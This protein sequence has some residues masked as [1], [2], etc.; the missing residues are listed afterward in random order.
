MVSG[1]KLLDKD[2]ETAVKYEA[3]ATRQ[4]CSQEIRDM[5]L[6]FYDYSRTNQVPK[7]KVIE[8]INKEFAFLNRGHVSSR[9]RSWKMGI[10]ELAERGVCLL[11]PKISEHRVAELI[12]DLYEQGDKEVST[13][14]VYHSLLPFLNKMGESLHEKSPIIRRALAITGHKLTFK[15]HRRFIEDTIT[16]YYVPHKLAKEKLERLQFIV[17]LK[18]RIAPDNKVW[19]LIDL[20]IAPR[21]DYTTD[22]YEICLDKKYHETPIISPLQEPFMKYILPYKHIRKKQKVPWRQ[23]MALCKRGEGTTKETL[24]TINK[25]IEMNG[26]IPYDHG[27]PVFERIK[28]QGL[29]IHNISCASLQQKP[30]HFRHASTGKRKRPPGREPC[31]NANSRR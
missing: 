24:D 31:G 8:N 21:H 22:E 1:V 30:I 28:I 2:V 17:N 11:K 10:A 13:A 9:D 27:H 25:I 14:K 5:V 4:I 20:R 16:K 18:Q 15:H 3:Y 6:E 26:L 7:M 29:R 19:D 12:L 23:I